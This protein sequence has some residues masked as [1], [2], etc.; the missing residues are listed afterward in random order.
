MAV[1]PTNHNSIL[2]FSYFSTLH[3][4]KILEDVTSWIP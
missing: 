2:E 3:I 4:Q 1:A